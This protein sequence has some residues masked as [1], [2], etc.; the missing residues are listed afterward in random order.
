MMDLIQ[1]F[2]P[3]DRVPV[4][5]GTRL[6]TNHVADLMQADVREVASGTRCLD[7]TIPNEWSV[8][9]GVLSTVAGDVIADYEDHPLSIWSCCGS[10]SGE[11]DLKQLREHLYFLPSSPSAIPFHYRCCYDQHCLDDW[12]FSLPEKVAKE[13]KDVRYI[14]DI[15][16]EHK[17]GS[18]CYIDHEIPGEKPDT[19]LFS[20]HTCHP[21][22]VN[23]GI[24]NVAVLVELFK[25]IRS[26][27]R[28]FTY[29]FIIGP[30]YYTAAAVLEHRRSIDKV[31]GGFYLDLAGAN[32]GL[33]W[34][35]TS[36]GNSWIDHLLQSVASDYSI[37]VRESG[38]RGVIG[39]DE[40]FYDG[41][42]FNIPVA[43]VCREVPPEYHTSDDNI[44]SCSD[45][46]L[47][48]MLDFLMNTIM[49]AESETLPRL[50]VQGPVCLS[51]RRISILPSSP[52]WGRQSTQLAMKM[53][54]GR[55]SISQI[56]HESG[57]P[58]KAVTLFVE[59]LVSS[60]VLDC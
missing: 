56:A 12:G 2:A 32:T 36:S 42:G 3:L 59:E 20:A 60:G 35:R 51:R 9:R 48:E 17:S 54:D 31:L 41:P 25:W 45:S 26:E 10:F 57:L 37:E 16:T 7:W 55:H 22:Q 52:V 44:Q 4:C 39:N 13:L 24:A 1:R 6:L 30:E 58:L 50:N 19:I 34:S 47:T 40:M 5:M 46:R 29:R 53:M 49:T 11:M 33:A 15:D 8:N 21:G 43:P 27:P 38:Y 23:D 14:V 18:M 28:K